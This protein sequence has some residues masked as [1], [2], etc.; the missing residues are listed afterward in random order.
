MIAEKRKLFFSFLFFGLSRRELKEVALSIP[1]VLSV[2]SDHA[3]TGT[4]NSPSRP[5]A[6]CPVFAVLTKLAELAEA[7][8]WS[9]NACKRQRLEM[10]ANLTFATKT[11][12]MQATHIT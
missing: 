10:Y 3:T 2:Y 9:V 4:A 5:A 7:G 6:D 8:A 11:A 12:H 1:V